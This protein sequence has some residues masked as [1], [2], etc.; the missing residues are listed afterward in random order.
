MAQSTNAVVPNYGI[1]EPSGDKVIISVSIRGVKP[2]QKWAFFAKDPAEAANGDVLVDFK[3]REFCFEFIGK[4]DLSGK[5]YRLRLCDLP[6]ELNTGRCQC[7][8][9]KD[10]VLIVL[11]KKDSSRSWLSELSDINPADD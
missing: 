9:R 3:E 11:R 6:G 7:K 5:R 4:S 8:V 1:L 2:A 10:A